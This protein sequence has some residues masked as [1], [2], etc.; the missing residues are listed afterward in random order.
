M[1]RLELVSFPVRDARFGPRLRFADEVL[2]IDRAGLLDLVGRQADFFRSVQVDIARPGER[3]RIIHV[4]DAIEPRCKVAPAGA[5]TFP[6]FLGPPE[7]TGT[8]RT[9]R[10]EGFAVLT[11]GN[12][13]GAEGSQGLK[14]AIVD[15]AGP[16]AEYTPVGR[17]TNVVLRFEVA[18]GIPVPEA[19]QAI[20]LAGLRAATWL[21]EATRD[22]AP[23]R[24][25]SFELGPA[26]PALPRVV[27]IQPMMREG[28]I[29]TTFIYGLPVES[30]PLVLH[31]NEVLDGAIVSADYWIACHRI[32][33]YLYQNEPVVRALYRRHGHDLNFVAVIACRCLIVAEAEKR[34]QAAQVAKVAR[35]LA[36]QGAIITMSN[37]G[38]AY[39]DQMLICQA[40]EQA[41]IR[42]V[43]GVDEYSDTDGGDVP[44]VI[45][46]PEARAIV[47]CGNQ[48]ARV[49][50]PAMERV[51]GGDRFVTTGNSYEEAFRRHPAEPFTIG[52][53][54]IYAATA[55][56]G[57]GRLTAR[58]F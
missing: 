9:H 21:A 55:Q 34:R 40:V 19:V 58:E 52:I 49:D 43:L 32:P 3:T 48:E 15:M 18:E 25:E 57:F 45:Y 54:Q 53:R 11:T 56:V 28:D 27:Y 51:L 37:G 50:L 20:R 6:G 26:D 36:A 12:I 10:L 17:L 23:A 33:T 30:L 46:V 41:G 47:S 44:L 8:G 38:H 7:V 39:A 5:P 35:M 13:P 22:L 14:E 29:H 2:E 42:T 16:G 24:V 1:M 31:P 4:I